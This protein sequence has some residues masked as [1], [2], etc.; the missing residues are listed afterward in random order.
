MS[1]YTDFIASKQ[2]KTVDAGFDYICT[3]D[4]IFDYQKSCVEWAT[5]R[6]KAAL[7][8][9]TGLGKTNCELAWAEAV[10]EYTQKPVLILAPLCVSS[11]VE[12]HEL[13]Q[14]KKKSNTT[15]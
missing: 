8:L 6:G 15:T 14:N 12:L 13:K 3:H 10:E 1:A 4:W 5:K 7:F 2:L 9:D 11:L